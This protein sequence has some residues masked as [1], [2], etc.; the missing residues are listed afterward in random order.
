MEEYLKESCKVLEKNNITGVYE[1]I[2][3]YSQENRK[4]MLLDAGYLE[5]DILKYME[6][7]K[8]YLDENGDLQ[9]S[10][11]EKEEI[12]AKFKS[13]VLLGQYTKNKNV[14]YVLGLPGAGKSSLISK[15]KEGF[16]NCEF[17][18]IDADDFKFGVDQ[19]G[20]QVVPSF[21]NPKLKG[22]DINSIHELSSN[23]AFLALESFSSESYD[24]VLPKVGGNLDTI[25]KS[26]KSLRKKGYKIYIHFVFTTIET[27]LKRNLKRYRDNLAAGKEVR[28]VDPNYIINLG[29]RPLYNFIKLAETS[30]CDEF[31][32]W[33]GEKNPPKKYLL[34]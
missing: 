14:I 11:E 15:I 29:Y 23:L 27:S 17:L 10:N 20:K 33:N 13:N 22:I 30:S 31:V 9:L 5:Q 4:Q 19:N 1:S 16:K 25:R 7:S 8:K 12:I 26:I 6:D 3:D 18:Q 32:F 34:K 21:V 24:L 28:L 2:K